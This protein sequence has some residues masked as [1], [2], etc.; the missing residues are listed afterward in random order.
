L[1]FAYRVISR[2]PAGDK[3]L[4]NGTWSGADVATGDIVTGLKTTET[5]TL[6]SVANGTT[7][8]ALNLDEVFPCGGTVTIDFTTSAKGTFQAI[9]Y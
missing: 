7:A 3:W 6:T 1:A 5:M 2:L 9:C 4:V 8:I